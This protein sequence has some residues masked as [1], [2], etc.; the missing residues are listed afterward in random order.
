MRHNFAA[1]ALLI[2]GARPCVAQTLSDKLGGMFYFTSC[3]APLCLTYQQAT[4]GLDYTYRASLASSTSLDFFGAAVGAALSGIPVSATSSG[5][6]F[7]FVD[8]APVTTS[9]SAGPIFAERAQTLGRGR[10]LLNV[11]ATQ[12]ALDRV[13]GMN[14]RDV[15]FNFDPRDVNAPGAGDYDIMQV[16]PWIRLTLKTA[17]AA[18]T[19]GLT[20]RID[21]GVVL[22]VVAASLNATSTASIV[23]P[24]G[25]ISGNHLFGT[26][27]APTNTATSAVQG[28]FTGVGDIAIR[29]K[30]NLKR[31]GR[32]GV[33]LLGDVRLP[34]G[35]AQNFTGTGHAD[36]RALAI[37]SGLQSDFSPHVNAGIAIRGG[38]AQHSGL[39]LTA[40][41]DHRAA[42]WAT[43]AIDVISEAQLGRNKLQIPVATVFNNGMAYPSTNVPDRRH[44]NPV[45]LSAGAKFLVHGTTLFANG[46]VPLNDAGVQAS[47][48]LALGIERTF[49]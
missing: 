22:P 29:A 9:T 7:R 40:G 34:T 1:L 13:R 33:A 4:H 49:R 37:V 17:S 27:A 28:S 10:M 25:P 46:L 12:V 45:G 20:D 42:S 36:V 44:D 30:A 3:E 26:D 48:V 14:L 8:G 19:Y 15:V 23:S 43:V 18:A 39:L 38:A 31:T 16:R 2:A 41:F 35:N 24:V 5:I 6:T 11:N 21:V 47:R 32:V